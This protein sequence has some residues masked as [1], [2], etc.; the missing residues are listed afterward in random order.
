[1]NQILLNIVSNAIKFTDAG[2]VVITVGAADW[3]GTQITLKISVQD[4]GIG[5]TPDQQSRLFGSFTQADNSTTRRFGGTGLGLAISKQ[6]VELMDGHIDVEST[7][8][9]G[10][11]FTFTVKMELGKSASRPRS[12]TSASIQ[13]LRA[14]I[15][16]D[17][18]ASRE[19][20][21]DIFGSWSMPVDLVA[22]GSE[23]L[24]A[25]ETASSQGSPYDLLIIDW[26]MPGM[27]GL[28]TVQALRAN[29]NISRLPLIVLITAYGHDE[30]RLEAERS[31]VTALLAKPIDPAALL[32]TIK[33]QFS[34]KNKDSLAS[35]A[36]TNPTPMVAENLRGL[37]VLVAEDNE[38]NREIAIELLTDAGLQVDTVEDGRL[39]CQRISTSGA[40]YAAVLMDVQMSGM[41]GVEATIRIRENWSKDDLPIIAMTAHAYESERLRCLA[42]GMNDHIAKPVNPTLLV[43]TLERWLKPR[44]TGEWPAA[45]L[46]SSDVPTSQDVLPS[47]LPPFDLVKALSRVNGKQA[48]LRRL[49]LEFGRKFANTMPTMRNHLASGALLEARLLAHTLKGVAASL[50][51]EAVAEAASRIETMLADGNLAESDD[52]LCQLE[53]VL[54]PALAAAIALGGFKATVP[55]QAAPGSE[56]DLSPMLS[57]LRLLLERR[58]MRARSVFER[59]RHAL[60]AAP[61]AVALAPLHDALSRL[62]FSEALTI[63]DNLPIAYE[64]INRYE[65]FGP[66]LCHD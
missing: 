47:C 49:I 36:A 15:A 26:K 1:M 38:I 40:Q 29:P 37:W 2:K 22:S 45:D 31:G 14:L 17:N 62:A 21:E 8:G 43:R 32:E 57:E 44:S 64:T 27:D 7:P 34:E 33:S 13:Q 35:A 3:Q 63:L 20:L 60:G 10:S 18:P 56:V 42:S 4:T 30:I 25:I 41:D 52:R 12:V 58:S 51:L 54:L 11:I 55:Q 65:I 48:L 66:D 16:D 5:I 9:V 28:E 61:E 53:D 23:A 6:L 46:P 50:E 39:A 19:I 24:G 59:L